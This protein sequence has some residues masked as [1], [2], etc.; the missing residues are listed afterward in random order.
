MPLLYTLF[1]PLFFVHSIESSSG[2]V[3]PTAAATEAIHFITITRAI[4]PFLWPHSWGTPFT[5]LLA[6]TWNRNGSAEMARHWPSKQNKTKQKK[7]TALHLLLLC[8]A[9]VSCHVATA[10]L[11][12]QF[13]P[14][15]LGTS[16]SS[17]PIK[18]AFVY[19]VTAP[20]LDQSII[21]KAC[22]QSI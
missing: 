13:R 21:T 20:S 4:R 8:V 19:A 10:A 22:A 2:R 14:A 7:R 6:N 12:Q 1:S 17:F 15:A 3:W 9:S 11:Y 18:V 5:R 16:A